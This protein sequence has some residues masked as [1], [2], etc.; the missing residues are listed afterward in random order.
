MRKN[1]KFLHIVGNNK[2]IEPVEE[3]LPSSREVALFGKDPRKAEN[4]KRV[5]AML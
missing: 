2:L 3:I 4:R 1:G 5:G